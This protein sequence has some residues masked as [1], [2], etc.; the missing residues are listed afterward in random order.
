MLICLPWLLTH[1]LNLPIYLPPRLLKYLFTYLIYLPTW[2]TYIFFYF[3]NLVTNLPTQYLVYLPT[4]LVYPTTYFGY[5]KRKSIIYNQF[6]QLKNS[7]N[8]QLQMTFLNY[9]S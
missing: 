8:F 1:L 5:I 4:Y 9:K 3:L 6:L 2:D 7:Y